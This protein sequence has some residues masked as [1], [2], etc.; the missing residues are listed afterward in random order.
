MKYFILII[1]MMIS[2]NVNAKEEVDVNEVCGD[3]EKLAR[4]FMKAKQSGI[5]LKTM[6]EAIDAKKGSYYETLLLDAYKQQSF[7]SE[8]YRQGAINEFAD[9][10][11]L[12]C[13]E[14]FRL[15]SKD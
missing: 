2:I 11:Y 10:S 8:E 1:M 6:V 15:A 12:D 14:V 3:I 13:L 7:N 4:S 9:S 5:P